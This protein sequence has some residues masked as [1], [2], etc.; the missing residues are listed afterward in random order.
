VRYGV[1]VRGS[2]RALLGSGSG[3]GIA[4]P[5]QGDAVLCGAVPYLPASASA[6]A[7][8]SSR[9]PHISLFALVQDA[10]QQIFVKTV[11]GKT[12]TLDVE[13]SDTIEIVKAKIQAKDGEC[14][15]VLPKQQSKTSIM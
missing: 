14:F 7:S 2:P 3:I 15:D 13:P 4:L 11:S 9:T 10:R 12:I 8:A 5:A 1:G 6:S